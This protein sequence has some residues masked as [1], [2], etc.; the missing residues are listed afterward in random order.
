MDDTLLR[1]PLIFRA[2]GG[3]SGHVVEEPVEL[4]D[5]M[6]TF[7]DLA[8]I[9]PRHT[10]FARSLIPQLREGPGDPNRPVFSEGGYNASEAHA[11]EPLELFPES[12]VYYPKILLENK[13][14][15][16][17]TRTTMIR[18]RSDKLVLRPGGESEQYD[19]R[20]DPRELHNV[21]HDRSYAGR[22]EDLRAQMLEWYIRTSD[23]VPFRRDDRAMPPGRT[24]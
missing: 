24:R 1:V 11:F 4:H 12:H 3:A 20:R 14:P 5:V 15:E 6:P 7:L 18:T 16:L 2:P 10:H 22:R 13:R 23:A 9:E 17:I 19:L 21:F 8:G